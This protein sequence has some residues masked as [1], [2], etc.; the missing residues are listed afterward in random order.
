MRAPIWSP[1][2]QLVIFK[3]ISDTST[4]IASAP[5]TRR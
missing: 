2:D 1:N 5:Y 3:W 4:K